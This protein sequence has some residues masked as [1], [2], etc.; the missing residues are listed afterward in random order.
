ME[1]SC[2]F[3]DFSIPTS[4]LDYH[5]IPIAT[6]CITAAY[7]TLTAALFVL[8]NI[9]YYD[10]LPNDPLV[11]YSLISNPV[12]QLIPGKI[13]KFP[14]SI[15]LS[16]LIDTKLWKFILNLINL[17]IGGSSIERNWNSSNEM[18]KYILIIGSITNLVVVII[19]LLSSFVI[20]GIKLNLPLDGNYT[21]LIGFPIIYRQLLPETTIINI[22]EPSFLSKNFRFKLLPILIQTFMT[23]TQ[24]LF[25][26]HFA[27]LMS[28]WIT[29]F[30]CWVYL[31]FFQILPASATG[32][33]SDL[34]TP[35]VG[36]ASDTFQLI[37]FFPDIIKPLLKP[38][39]SK[40][41]DI[42]CVKYHLIKPFE[43]TDVDK[44]NDI[45]E[46]RGAKKVTD[47]VQDRRRQLALDVLQERLA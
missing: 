21:V 43:I 12:L 36:D 10:E 13:L 15:V 31:R 17:L 33:T 24:L 37:Y 23:I 42:V 44:G 26:H 22:K 30:S 8:R 29:F 18:I 47:A 27:N 46:Q 14:Y 25:F 3:F 19:T 1:Y 28:I 16:N 35:V 40:V 38:I 9:K 5:K 7:V 34:Y 11:D 32:S 6:K 2:R 4:A 45:A 41:H 39:F 20:S